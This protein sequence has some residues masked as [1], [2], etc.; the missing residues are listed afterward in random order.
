MLPKLES[1]PA[2]PLQELLKA[3]AITVVCVCTLEGFSR[4]CLNTVA[5]TITS[6]SSTLHSVL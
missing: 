6:N 5:Q 3:N 2:S 4:K 1:V